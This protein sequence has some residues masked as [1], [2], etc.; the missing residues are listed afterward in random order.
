MLKIF[1]TGTYLSGGLS[2]C[3]RKDNIDELFGRGHD[4]NLFEVVMHHGE[5]DGQ[6]RQDDK[7]WPSGSASHVF[8][9]TAAKW[10][11]LTIAQV[12]FSFHQ[13]FMNSNQNNGQVTFRQSPKIA[14]E[15]QSI[16][17]VH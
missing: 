12:S 3:F 10:V 4:R 14:K 9:S 2:L 17:Q 11:L 7:Q 16:L 6:Q 8:Y 5:R 15:K 1:L 13:T